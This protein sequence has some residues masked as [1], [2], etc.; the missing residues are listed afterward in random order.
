[1]LRQEVP[2]PQEAGGGARYGER[3]RFDTLIL[4]NQ[5]RRDMKLIG[6]L[7]L[8]LSLCA[9]LF[10]GA[11]VGDDIKITVYKTPTCGCC[12]KWVSHL[13]QNGFQVETKDLTNLGMIKSMAGV[14]P[15]LASCH[16]ARVEGYIVE[17]HV[18]AD[19]IKRLLR[20]RPA[21][22]GLTTPGMPHGS[23][24]MESVPDVPFE[25]LTFDS[26]GKTEVFAHH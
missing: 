21:V 3:D 5:R 19:D 7:S 14:K 16:T 10:A 26:D 8:G 20:E 11:A 25:V 17:G 18:P 22:K 1:M 12:T 9:A 4:D 23:P 6:N 13:E 15:E 2:E 24:G